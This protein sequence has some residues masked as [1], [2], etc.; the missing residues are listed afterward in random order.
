MIK[1]KIAKTLIIEN[2]LSSSPNSPTLTMLTNINK[3]TITSGP[4]H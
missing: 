2:Q 4:T 1:A 3:I